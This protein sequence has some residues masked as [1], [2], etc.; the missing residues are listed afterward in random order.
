MEPSTTD[1]GQRWI[2]NFDPKDRPTAS[3]LL[4]SI[5]FIGQD[6]LRAALIA[7]V[8]QLAQIL[9]TPIALV[10]AR[11]LGPNQSYFGKDRNARPR[12]LL[13]NSFPGSEAI[14]ANIAGSVRRQ[15]QSAGPFVATTRQIFLIFPGLGLTIRRL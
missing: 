15:R 5:E 1:R 10:P 6:T 8:H 13:D 3:F 12:L 9:P 4:D 7:L 2:E 11:E 14:I